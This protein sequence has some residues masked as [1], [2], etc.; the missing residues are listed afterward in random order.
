MGWRHEEKEA[1]KLMASDPKRA[2]VLVRSALEGAK[3]SKLSHAV[4]GPEHEWDLRQLEIDLESD[5]RVGLPQ[6]ATR[7][8][9][10]LETEISDEITKVDAAL[11]HITDPG[12]AQIGLEARARL[13]TRL[14][15]QEE[16]DRSILLAADLL[17]AGLGDRGAQ[18]GAAITPL[19][20]LGH[21]MA[22]LEYGDSFRHGYESGT[23]GTAKALRDR[24]VHEG[25][26]V[27]IAW[28]G[29]C[30]AV[31]EA[32]YK[33]SRC[34]PHHHKVDVVRVVVTSDEETARAELERDARVRSD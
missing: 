4:E 26:G 7:H 8:R 2:L 32:D 9:D 22:G 17:L 5:E 24:V 6:E 25:R 18:I 29:K 19:Y 20:I 21:G 16:A 14:G 34:A 10:A 11:E 30:A 1:R 33:K 15:R 28:C 3:S 23:R 13:L 31:V 12:A 27:A